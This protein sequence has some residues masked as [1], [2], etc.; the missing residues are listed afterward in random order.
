MILKVLRR[1]E[2]IRHT[3]HQ[4]KDNHPDK[5]RDRIERSFGNSRKRKDYTIH[6]HPHKGAVD[7]PHKYLILS[8][9][10]QTWVKQVEQQSPGDSNHEMHYE[11]GNCHG[12]PTVERVSPEESA[13]YILQQSFGCHT[14]LNVSAGHGCK[15]I[16]R[17]GYESCSKNGYSK[18]FSG[19]I[20]CN[21]VSRIWQW[22]V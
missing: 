10:T 20:S 3:D 5:R 18:R 13:S 8:Q 4:H 15:N 7:Y 14:P 12:S 9:N 11:S 21:I 16:Q 2:R 1:A 19:A 6:H 17:S 22:F